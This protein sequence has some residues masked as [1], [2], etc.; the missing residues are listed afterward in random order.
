M[1]YK[2][3]PQISRFLLSE[4]KVCIFVIF[5]QTR[6]TDN[7][8]STSKSNLRAISLSNDYANR[9]S[10]IGHAETVMGF[11]DGTC[12]KILPCCNRSSLNMM[13]QNKRKSMFMDLVKPPAKR[14]TKTE[15]N[16]ENANPNRLHK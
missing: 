15:D 10:L 2:N 16:T 3:I 1:R 7:N 6:R 14:S 13:R 8:H 9:H 12:P 4:D 11:G 5:L